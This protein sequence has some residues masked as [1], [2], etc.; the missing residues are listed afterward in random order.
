VTAKTTSARLLSSIAELYA[1]DALTA[2]AGRVLAEAD[3]TALTNAPA[4]AIAA[5]RYA[6][7][8]GPAEVAIPISEIL[9]TFSALA[10]QF[11]WHQNPH[12]VAAPPSPDFLD[13]YGYVEFA[14]PGRAI[15]V[16]DVR[17]GVLLLGPRTVYP[18]HLHAAEEVYHVISGRARWWRLGQEWRFEQPGAAIHH[19]P[20]LPHATAC[21]DE[22]LLA[23]YCWIGDIQA[24]ARLMNS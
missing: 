3:P 21:G 17:V 15:D 24:A 2:H 5:T 19:P 23:L 9:T 13:N 14:G 18:A 4:Q 8:I 10:G 22:P 16:N 1:R 11:V 6:A 7:R 12:Y 20:H